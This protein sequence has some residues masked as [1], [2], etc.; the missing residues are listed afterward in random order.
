M[1]IKEMLDGNYSGSILSMDS[2]TQEATE[3]GKCA[4][5][6]LANILIAA[7]KV[8]TEQYTEDEP[9]A[10]SALVDVMNHLAE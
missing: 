9:D 1:L 5:E 6:L 4:S 2:S 7:D 3:I 10:I 8:V